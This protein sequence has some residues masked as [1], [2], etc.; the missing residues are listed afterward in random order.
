MKKLPLM[1]VLIIL[2]QL[3]WAQESVQINKWKITNPQKIN[4]PA[5]SDVKN[6][7]GKTFEASKLL[8]TTQ[9]DLSGESLI[10][11]N[12]EVSTD[13]IVLNQST[14]NNLVL[15]STYLSLDQWTQGSLNLNINAYCEIFVDNKLVK[16]KSSAELSDTKIE[17]D[18]QSGNHEITIK[19]ITRDTN[20]K[21]VANFDYSEDFASCNATA[22][23]NPE[24]FFTIDDLMNSKD[25]S[26]SISASG[27]YILINYT[28]RAGNKG[29]S[30]TY[31]AIYDLAKQK[32]ITVLRNKNIANVSWLPRTDRLTY[33]VNFEKKAEIFVYDII[34]GIEKSIAN[35]IENLYW[36]TWSPNENYIIYTDKITAEKPGNLKRI[37]GNDDRLPYFRDRSYLHKIDVQSGNVTQLTSGNLTS[38]LND[39]KPDGSKILISTS[40]MDYSEV[41]FSKQNLYEMDIHTNELTVI[42]ENKIYE[43]YASYSPNGDKL[44]VQGG[45]ECFGDIGVNISEG[46]IPNSYDSQLYIYDLA[47]KKVES[48]SKDFDPSIGNAYWSKD[49]QIYVSTTDRDYKNLYQYNFKTKAFAK[50]NLQVE[51]LSSINYAYEKAVA[52]YTGTSI[53]TPKKLYTLDLKK[54]TSTLLEFPEEEKFANIKFGKTEPWNFTNKSG[55]TIY[56]RV[57]YPP[58][59]DATK[60]YPVIVNFYGGTSPIGRSF[61]GRYPINIWTAGNYIVYVLQPSGATGFGQDFSA[62][63]VNG[64][65]FDAIDDIIV[66]TNK[67][68]EAHPNADVENVG[69]IG[70]SYGGYTTML[71]Q[72]RTDIFKT[73][74]SHAGI[75]SLTSYWGE[76]YWGYTYNA[77]AARNSYPWDRK[78]IYVENS[79]IY[80]ADKFQN[81]ILLLHGTADTNV[82]VG[83][84]LQYYA[85]LKILG[86]DVEMVLVDNQD[87]WI[88]DYKKRIE[89]H[90]TIM[91][92]FDKKLKNQSQQWDNLYPEKNL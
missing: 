67:F 39:I 82:P 35:E 32:N 56:G 72:T 91:S 69:C 43:A 80:N 40:R 26:A 48:I 30:K 46:R 3:S 76:G 86:K 10:W 27:K 12:I 81:S 63:H 17:L 36:Y 42:W 92:W 89:W 87:H 11:K 78:D 14:K 9:V 31:S 61:G 25:A 60:K 45:S 50:I 52:V 38:S 13:S 5:F 19:A 88:L 1:L 79:P 47:S 55:T 8:N 37:Y 4:M 20:L 71:I 58:N 65:G 74:I 83:E 84:S 2:V 34:S 33:S 85:A 62:L 51:V 77:G 75:S 7:D 64:W 6:I 70:A 90:Y 44:L 15:L 73:A 21:L 59:Y 16:T 54:G 29:K 57:Y 41:P 53:S 28:E 24:K 68:L 22:S 49:N 18:L 23:L 66:G